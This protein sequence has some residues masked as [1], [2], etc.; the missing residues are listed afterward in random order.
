MI[1]G[2][3]RIKNPTKGVGTAL[4]VAM[5]P[6]LLIGAVYLGLSEIAPPPIQIATGAIVV[7]WFIREVVK[8]ANRNNDND[9][10]HAKRP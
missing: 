10:R 6:P 4:L 1:A 7:C 9:P 5:I 3:R 8:L 2:M